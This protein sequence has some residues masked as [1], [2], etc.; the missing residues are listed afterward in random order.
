MCHGNILFCLETPCHKALEQS[1]RKWIKEAEKHT[2]HSCRERWVK[3]T[4]PTHN[5]TVKG[6]VWSRPFSPMHRRKKGGDSHGP[7][8]FAWHP[9]FSKADFWKKHSVYTCIACP[10]ARKPE[11][12]FTKLL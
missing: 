2:S 4:G 3:L 12:Y 1:W 10:R 8:A 5:W 11:R 7:L 9:K 6:N